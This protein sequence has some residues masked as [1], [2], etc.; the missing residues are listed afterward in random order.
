MG[1][2]IPGMSAPGVITASRTTRQHRLDFALKIIEKM[3][4]PRK[5]SGGETL[6]CFI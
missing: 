6:F 5:I 1:G 2:M 3:N 4:H